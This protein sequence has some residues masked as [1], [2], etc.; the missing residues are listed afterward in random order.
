MGLIAAFVKAKSVS[1]LASLLSQDTG[2]GEGV[3]RSPDV[4]VGIWANTLDK[5]SHV[6]EVHGRGLGAGNQQLAL[7][8]VGDWGDVG[9]D[10]E[11]V[12]GGVGS[13]RNAVDLGLDVVLASVLGE[14]VGTVLELVL[15]VATTTHGDSGDDAVGDGAGAGLDIASVQHKAGLVVGREADEARLGELD[16]GAGVADSEKRQLHPQVDDVAEGGDLDVVGDD[17]VCDHRVSKTVSGVADEVAG[18]EGSSNQWV[19]SSAVAS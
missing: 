14:H 6:R 16:V 15:L 10:L 11:S 2:L 19:G 18:L 5:V 3:E 13:G 1:D 7:D 9:S 12:A 4:A 17:G 8:P